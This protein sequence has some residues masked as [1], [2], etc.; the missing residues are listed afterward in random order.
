MRVNGSYSPILQDV[1][2][3][4]AKANSAPANQGRR[5]SGA[6]PQLNANVQNST[7]TVAAEKS[8]APVAA[9]GNN[10]YQVYSPVKPSDLSSNHQQALSRYQDTQSIA[11]SVDDAGEYL[12]GVDIYV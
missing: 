2:G 12:G 3:R 7:P 9:A 6:P 10:R 5:D 1:I 11:R 8:M 4:S